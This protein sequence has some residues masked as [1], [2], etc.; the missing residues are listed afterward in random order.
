M[1]LA[2]EI[3]L[4]PLK[5]GYIPDIQAFIDLLN[6]YKGLTVKTN[7]MSTQICGEF[8]TVM[9]VFTQSMKETFQEGFKAVFVC[10]FL[11]SDITE[12]R[13]S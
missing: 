11:N 1:K 10:K 5:D 3:S 4:Y 9:T 7:N 12:G 6:Q 2:V 13:Y 8:D